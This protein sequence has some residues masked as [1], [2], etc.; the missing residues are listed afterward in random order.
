MC[1]ILTRP[2]PSG[3]RYCAAGFRSSLAPHHTRDGGV[4]PPS[5]SCSSV[6]MSCQCIHR[7][8]PT[9]LGWLNTERLAE[10]QRSAVVHPRCTGRW[11][12]GG[13]PPGWTCWQRNHR[14]QV[15]RC[16]PSN[17]IL[18][19]HSA[20]FTEGALAEVRK[21]AIRDALAVLRGEPPCYPVPRSRVAWRPQ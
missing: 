6:W 19:P 3:H 2:E 17:V 8:P 13:S 20:A 12:P 10:M 21:T 1:P 16:S 9:R 15:V 5:R 11:S 7:R 14:I 18:T 4:T